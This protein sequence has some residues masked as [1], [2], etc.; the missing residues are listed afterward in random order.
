M[1][2]SGSALHV[3]YVTS[4]FPLLSETF[5]TMEVDELERRGVRVDL[6]ALVRERDPIRHPEAA[7]LAERCVFPSVGRVAVDQLRWLIRHPRRYGWMWWRALAGNLRSPKFLMRAVIVAPIA[8]SFSLG[9]QRSGADHIHAHW[10]THS[11]LAAYLMHLLTGLPFSITAHAHDLF[12]DTTMLGEKLDAAAAIVTISDY[13]RRELAE[14]YGADV[15]A[16]VAVVRCGVDLDLF[17]G[18]PLD[19]DRPLSIVSVGSLEFRKGHH[20]LVEACERL[21]TAGV[22]ATCM[23]VGEGAERAALEAR[24]RATGLDDRVALVGARQRYEVVETLREADVFVLPSITLDTGKSEGIPV[25]LMEA[26]AMRLPVI[27]THMTGIPELVTDGENGYLIPEGDVGV[28]ADRLE[29]LA[30]KVEHRLELGRRGRQ[31]VEEEFALS[32]NVERLLQVFLSV[33]GGSVMERQ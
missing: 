15:A 9:V 14:R 17:D 6:H 5:I 10:A 31:R 4:R 19:V 8:A 21:R 32:A 20:L 13:N 30:T 25:A 12:V 16:K 33:P 1:S 26:M 3:A 23:I 11:G 22:E 28:L 29:Q 18:D 2:E 7:R 27:A 24:I